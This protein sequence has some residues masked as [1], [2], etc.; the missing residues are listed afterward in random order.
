MLPRKEFIVDDKLAANL[1]LLGGCDN[2]IIHYESTTRTLRRGA[3]SA[4]QHG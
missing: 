3:L 2:Q 4:L 1:A